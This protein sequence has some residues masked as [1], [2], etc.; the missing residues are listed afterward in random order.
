MPLP[1]FLLPVLALALGAAAPAWA[2]GTP[3]RLTEIDEV[4]PTYLS[5]PPEPDPMFYFG[6]DS[7]GAQGRIYPYPLYNNLT[8]VKADQPYHVVYLE[9]E[10]VKIGVIPALGG[11]LFSAVDKTDGYDFVYRQHVIKPALIGLIGAWISGGIEWN[12]PHHHRATTFLPVQ[13]RTEEHPDGSKTVWVG[14]LE[15]RQ[16][17]RWAVGY[18]L[19]PGSSVLEASVRI[20]NRTPLANTMLCFANVAVPANDQYQIIFPPSTQHVAYHF[21]RDFADWPIAHGMFNGADFGAGTDV[22]WYK[23]H[24]S[25]NSMFAWNYRD[26]FFAGYDHGR[27]AGTISVADHHIV[28]G[29]KFWTWGNGPRG[30]TWDKILTDND[31]P[32]VELMVGA[33]SDNQPDYS[34]LQP[35]ETRSFEMR[36]YPFRG[37]GGVKNANADAAV[38]LEVKDGQARFGFCT[39]GA[40]PDARVRVTAAGAVLLDQETAID[41]AHPFTGQV[42]VPAGV[43]VHE[44]RAA[45][46]ENGRELVGY[47]PVRLEPEARPPVVTPP[48]APDAVAT[49]E[50]LDL[51]G[52]RIDQFHD[53]I[54]EAEPYWREALRRDPGDIEAH[55]GLGR[56]DLEAAR[57]AS[58]EAHFRKALERLTVR[59]TSPKD[60]EPYYYLGVALQGEDRPDAAYDAFY[61]AAWSQEW[62]APA[63]F[64]LAEIACA[65][66]DYPKALGFVGQS[67]EANAL[68]VRALGLQAALLRHLRRPDEAR[69]VLADAA[70]RTDPLDARLMA[71]AWLLERAPAH[72]PLLATLRV[73]PANAQ[74]LAAEYAD[75]GLWEDAERLLQAVTQTDPQASPLLHYYLAEVERRL[76]HAASSARELRLAASRSPEYV[77]PFQTEMIPVLRQAMAGAPQDARAPYYLGNLLFDGQPGE[78]VR[79]WRL[80]AQLD[81][82]F[83]VVWRN[84]AQAAAHEGR[85]EEAVADL[86]KAVALSDA[87]P[88][89]FAELDELYAAAAKAPAERL[90]LL[91][92]HEGAARKN[93]EALASLIR[94]K[95]FAGKADE[96]I[97]L[98]QGHIFNIWEG[99]SPFDTGAAWTEAQLVAGLSRLDAGQPAEALAHFQAAAKFP[100]NLRVDRGGGGGAELAYWTGCAEDKLGSTAAAR[101]AWTEATAVSD[102]SSGRGR[103]GESVAI[104][105]A[106]R[107]YQALAWRKLGQEE[108]AAALVREL[109]S[110]AAA[111]SRPED[112]APAPFRLSPAERSAAAHYVAGLAAAGAGDTA[113]ARGEW[114]AALAARPDDL[115]AKIALSRP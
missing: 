35:Y 39:T 41:P 76:G 42:G 112:A 61:K 12:I 110:L 28:P 36:W 75:A 33:Y 20:L 111:G 96:A 56:L 24:F 27:E 70:R 85:P 1:R 79:L 50:E 77:F 14:E 68:N 80:S 8:N 30:R 48:P 11:K 90:A 17:M 69:A 4:I 78:A 84:L 16:R 10:Y 22:S 88:E 92:K 23:N 109:S 49:D 115:G 98:L 83:P 59:Y 26:D 106:R 93:D 45:L 60:A 66:G 73:Q 58:A 9:N 51:T 34:W 43:D 114:Q 25:A 5:G 102:A 103:F 63:Y 81:P 32:Y 3:V 65:Q 37:I 101:E 91:E 15:I 38:N 57:Y 113:Q 100:D 94:L 86:E 82:S 29:K 87:Y 99:A 67:L 72:A 95:T 13:Y 46:V 74:E 89:N 54:H 21:K 44:V 55:K 105:G 6:R 19:R 52:Q 53:P 7:Q 62:K 2:Q 18:T 31:G 97:A 108:R 71:E 40:W 107:Y 64:S 47:A 104:R